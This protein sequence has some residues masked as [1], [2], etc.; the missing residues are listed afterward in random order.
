MG[1][2][3]KKNPGHYIAR[4]ACPGQG[5]KLTSRKL[6][7]KVRQTI[8]K[9][10]TAEFVDIQDKNRGNKGS[11]SKDY[12]WTFFGD[13]YVVYTGQHWHLDI[14]KYFRK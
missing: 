3:L 14:S 13:G 11:R 10:N 8:A 6:R 9:N 1:K 2:S 4:G 7:R 12:G 5:K